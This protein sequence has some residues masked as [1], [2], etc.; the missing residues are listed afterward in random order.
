M[1]HNYHVFIVTIEIP[2]K[3]YY[4]VSIEEIHS[5]TNQRNEIY[6]GAQLKTP[7][8]KTIHKVRCPYRKSNLGPV[9]PAPIVLTTELPKS[10]NISLI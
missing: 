10:P 2:K 6:P 7:R 5:G 8:P 9:Q 4:L 3:Y 1:K